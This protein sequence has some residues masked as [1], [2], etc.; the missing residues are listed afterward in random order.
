MDGRDVAVARA[1]FRPRECA[2]A[3]PGAGTCIGSRPSS[4]TSGDLTDTNR[5]FTFGKRGPVKEEWDL[6]KTLLSNCA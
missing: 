5:W 4:Q 3:E 1:V 2:G 6:Y